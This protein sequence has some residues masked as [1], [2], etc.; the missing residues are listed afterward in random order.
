MVNHR[1]VAVTHLTWDLLRVPLV[2]GF[3]V[4][5]LEKVGK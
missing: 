5:K 2:Y 3:I 1:R 4:K